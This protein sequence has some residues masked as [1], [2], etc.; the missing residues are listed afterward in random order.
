MTQ[1]IPITID[2]EPL[3]KSLGLTLIKDAR[4]LDSKWFFDNY[5]SQISKDIVSFQDPTKSADLADYSIF[6]RDITYYEDPS[7]L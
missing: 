4:G 1:G 7:P 6:G 5:N 2:L 3:M